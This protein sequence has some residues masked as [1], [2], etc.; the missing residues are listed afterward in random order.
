[1]HDQKIE[2]FLNLTKLSSYGFLLF[3]VLSLL[4]TVLFILIIY[5]LSGQHVTYIKYILNNNYF[6]FIRNIKVCFN[7]QN[8]RI[9]YIN[10]IFR[11]YLFNLEF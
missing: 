5:F 4:K 10:Q 1:M 2:P 11:V 8:Y 3:G 6:E 9:T 7:L